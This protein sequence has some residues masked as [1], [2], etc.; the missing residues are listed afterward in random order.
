ME[1]RYTNLLR[2]FYFSSAIYRFVMAKVN[3]TYPKTLRFHCTKCG[4]CCGDTT[5]KIRHVLLL[6]TE[7]EEIVQTTCQP[8]PKFA[9]SIK[10][11]TPY[12]FEMK[13][14]AEDRKCVFL[15]N[16][17]CTIYSLRPIICRFYPFELK[18]SSIRKNMFLFTEECQG[19]NKG[20]ILNEHYF[21][22]MIKLAHAKFKQT[23]GSNEGK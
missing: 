20:K 15:K 6:R 23:K 22:K 7:A 13:K 21:R 11:K 16:N 9:V 17:R 5:E 8:I 2:C 12:A 4:I 19:I 1:Q 18:V 10:N 14:R 3:F